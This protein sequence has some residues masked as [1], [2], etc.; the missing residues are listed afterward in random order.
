VAGRGWAKDG[1]VSDE[2]AR[3]GACAHS[4]LRPR[5]QLEGLQRQLPG[6][7]YNPCNPYNSLSITASLKGYFGGHRAFHIPH[8]HATDFA[9][10]KH[11]DSI[12][13]L[14]FNV[15]RQIL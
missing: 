8:C 12:P 11:A 10:I 5:L 2:G 4:A 15:I 6:Q 13:A 7:P 14:L 3:P 1:G 9:P